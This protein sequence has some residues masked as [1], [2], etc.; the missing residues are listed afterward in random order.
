MN[1]ITKWVKYNTHIVMNAKEKEKMLIIISSHAKDSIYKGIRC[2]KELRK[3]G[4][5][6]IEQNTLMLETSYMAIS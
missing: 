4:G 3:Y 2:K 1:S 5:T 6:S